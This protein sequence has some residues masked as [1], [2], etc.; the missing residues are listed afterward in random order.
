MK[1]Q[2][3]FKHLNQSRRDRIE[4]LID[5][6]EKQKEI[7]KI[8]KV[9]KSTVSR[10]ITKRQRK[11]GRYDAD[12]AGRKAGVLRSNSKYQGMKIENN[13]PLKQ[14]IVAML[15]EYRSPDEIAGRL[16]KEGSIVLGKNAIYKW[17]YSSLGQRSCRYLCTKRYRR[18]KQKKVSKREMIPNRVHISSRPKTLGL[19]HLEGDTAVSPRKSGSKH[20]AA[21]IAEPFSSLFLGK[22]TKNLRPIVVSLALKETLGLLKADTITLDNGIENKNH[23]DIGIPSYFCDPHSPWQKPHVENGIGLMRRWF[24]PKGTDWKKVSANELKKYIHVLNSKYRKKLG[25]RSAY[26]VA[27]EKG[28][29]NFLP[30]TLLEKVAFEGGI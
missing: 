16:S 22:K 28:I 9:D 24:V 17:L 1:K 14:K 6:G 7:A 25:Y 10:E 26:E 21:F 11:D 15:K 12:T 8:L 5:A 20:A 30:K 18:R 19:I 3:R 23:A 29:I 27:Y 2:R 4:A 13:Q